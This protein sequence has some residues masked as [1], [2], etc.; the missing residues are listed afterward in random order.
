MTGSL[1]ARVI[2]WLKA[3]LSARTRRSLKHAYRRARAPVRRARR[4]R[5]EAIG[6]RALVR[7]LAEA[8]IAPGDVLLVHSSLSRI[9]NVDD[10]ARTVLASLQEAVTDEGTILMPAYGDAQTVLA[11]AADGAHVDLRTSA[12]LTGKISEV[13]RASPGVRR[14]SHP[15]S[16][17]CAW[18]R[19]A[20]FVTSGHPDDPRIAHAT[21]PFGRFVELEGKV[22]GLGVSLGPVSFYHVLED[23]WG[24]FPFSPYL[25]PVEVTYVDA[26]GAEITRQVRRYDPKVIRTRIDQPEGEWIRRRLTAHLRAIGLLREFRF[27]SAASW[28]IDAKPF[29]AE[30]KRLAERGVTIYS[31]ESDWS[32]DSDDL[33]GALATPALSKQ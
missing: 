30:L 4:Q 2:G 27:G 24:G 33:S 11:A 28:V 1:R 26:E 31:T 23:T 22:V 6:S 14:S 7:A 15:F 21:S 16:S 10:G 8:G 19:H 17:V 32:A 29:Y 18:G 20:E 12:A 5:L 25:D 13:F 9:G 3:H